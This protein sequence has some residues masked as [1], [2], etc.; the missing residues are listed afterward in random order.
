MKRQGESRVGSPRKV[1]K[2]TN[3]SGGVQA[4]YARCYAAGLRAPL[5]PS[6]AI[7]ARLFPEAYFIALEC[8]LRHLGAPCC[9]SRLLTRRGSGR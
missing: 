5:P 3:G 6:V 7:M 8:V 9:G 2:R 4:K 1:D